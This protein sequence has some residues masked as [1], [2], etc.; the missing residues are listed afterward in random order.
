MRAFDHE[1][2]FNELWPKINT[3]P[4]GDINCLHIQL[5]CDLAFGILVNIPIA[6]P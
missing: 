2:T 1:H 4:L 6:G 5:S 3:Y